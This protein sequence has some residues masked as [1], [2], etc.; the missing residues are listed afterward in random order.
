MF[1]MK[2]FECALR[3]DTVKLPDGALLLKCYDDAR[4][5][6]SVQWTF[7]ADVAV[8]TSLTGGDDDSDVQ[9]L[10]NNT[11]VIRD[12]GKS[13]E[14]NYSCSVTQ[15][16]MTQVAVVT[17]SRAP[18]VTI[19]RVPLGEGH[20][21]LFCLVDGSTSTPV[22]WE[23][24]RDGTTTALKNDD[25]RVQVL[26]NNTLIIPD[27]QE[28]DEGIYTCFAMKGG[29]AAQARAIV[30]LVPSVRIITYQA[31]NRDF[32]LTCLVEDAPGDNIS[33]TYRTSTSGSLQSLPAGNDTTHVQILH[34]STLLIRDI[35]VEDKGTY[36][37]NA[38]LSG[39]RWKLAHAVVGGGIPGAS[40]NTLLLFWSVVIPLS[41]YMN[42]PTFSLPG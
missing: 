30:R 37:C 42:Q 40:V 7:S 3:I 5:V 14:G 13:R 29:R 17:I 8:V 41:L 35:Q 25:E 10:S 1:V 4:V 28:E 15:D 31:E 34:N 19:T 9:V 18:Q 38:S 32:F 16:D 27:F 20:L 26:S 23:L 36:T 22:S 33:W 21:Q 2:D 24:L 12:F 11:L 39:G 6:Q